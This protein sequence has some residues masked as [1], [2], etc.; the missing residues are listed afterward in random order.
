MKLRKD[1][2]D[3]LARQIVRGLEEKTVIDTGGA[4]EDVAMTVA[5]VIARDL[6]VEDSLNDE[7]KQILEKQYS[8]IDKANINYH[9]MF[10]MV[11]QKLARERGLIL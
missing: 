3:Y 10:Q 4:Q 2:I 11:K 6:L 5:G 9:K 8:E 1:M 7:V